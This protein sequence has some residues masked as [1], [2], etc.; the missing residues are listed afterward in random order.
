M[1]RHGAVSWLEHRPEPAQ[2]WIRFAPTAWPDA[3]ALWID[4]SR[5]GLGSLMP[6]AADLASFEPPATDDL[7]WLPPVA[8]G[9]QEA[10]EELSARIRGRGARTLVQLL[11]G[12]P[13]PS[14]ADV[15]LVDLLSSGVERRV[16]RLP[17][18]AGAW[19]LWPLLPA[20]SDDPVR[21]ASECVRWRSEG[22]AGVLFPVLRL[23]PVERRSLSLGREEVF[24][25]LFHGQVLGDR[26]YLEIARAQGLSCWLPR[27]CDLES[28]LGRRRAVAGALSEIG[29][30]WSRLEGSPHRSESF[31]RAARELE[32][33]PW[34]LAALERE[35]NLGVLFRDPSRDQLEI[36]QVVTE[37]VTSGRSSLRDELLRRYLESGARATA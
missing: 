15:T 5:S 36:R 30:L 2:L 3:H 23:Q 21:F 22:A 17:I 37:L 33:S 35:G 24:E 4:L 32:A 6:S 19:V 1:T 34:D 26:T 25:A 31:F 7:V 16:T 27:P 8:D 13:A 29:E 20:L 11:P 14:A 9:L 18:P 12:Q 10:R 28:S